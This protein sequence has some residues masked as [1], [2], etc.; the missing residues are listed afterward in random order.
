VQS[1]LAKQS[2]GHA[3]LR[4]TLP[5]LFLRVA[6]PEE[7]ARLIIMI[8][9]FSIIQ[10]LFTKNISGENGINGIYEGFACAAGLI[11]GL[12]FAAVESADYA[13]REAGN[14][15]WEF[16]LLRL[17]SV[18]LH[19]SCA[20]RCGLA[21]RGIFTNTVRS[22]K[23]FATALV[24]HAFFDFILM[25]GGWRAALGILLALTTLVSALLLIRNDADKLDFKNQN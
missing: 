6:L 8:I 11:S 1:F 17:L 9:T 4:S 2:Y 16:A 22:V 15:N 20:M 5:Y 23:H 14:L 7:G 3:A 10:K 18:P 25:L 12:A 19:A 24:I 13:L 21:A